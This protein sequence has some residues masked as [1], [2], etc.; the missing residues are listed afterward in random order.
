MTGSV[1]TLISTDL[2]YHLSKELKDAAYVLPRSIV[3]TALVNYIIGFVMTI[4]IIS[5]LGILIQL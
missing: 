3:A 4:T 2:A 1:I 5:T